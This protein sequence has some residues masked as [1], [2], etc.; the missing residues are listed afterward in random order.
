[1]QPAE[2][3]IG[4]LVFGTLS[5]AQFLSFWHGAERPSE[6]WVARMA[7]NLRAPNLPVLLLPSSL[8]WYSAALLTASSFVEGRAFTVVGTVGLVAT[9]S[10]LLLTLVWAYRAPRGLLPALYRERLATRPRPRS[11]RASRVLPALLLWVQGGLFGGAYVAFRLDNGAFAWA[12]A[13]MATVALVA[14]VWRD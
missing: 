10:F 14:Y 6:R 13:V 12:L 9:L 5:M 4:C 2:L 7:I 8:A 11:G 1:M 3:L